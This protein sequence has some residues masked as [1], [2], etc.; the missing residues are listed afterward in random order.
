MRV[1]VAL[2]G[3]ALLAASCGEARAEAASPAS[4]S[5]GGIGVASGTAPLV[6]LTP[7]AIARLAVVKVSVPAGHGAGASEFEGPLLWTL[8]IAAHAV[9]ASD[10]HAQGRQ[11][12]LITGRD[13][14]VA[15]LA[16]GEISPEFEAKQVILAE[17][18]DGQALGGEH[19]RIVV[20]GDR[21][22]ARG[23]HDVVGIA[24]ETAARR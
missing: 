24:V 5:G 15:E 12:V 3:L 17:R 23:V 1:G 22:G 7:E 16:M 8:L 10:P 14:F 21:R 9:D 20:P 11:T 6:T 2:A 18:R 19:L 13:G 4:E